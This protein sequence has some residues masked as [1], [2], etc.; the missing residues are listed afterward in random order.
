MTEHKGLLVHVYRSALGGPDTTNGGVS[1]QH[2]G[3]TVVGFQ[4]HDDAHWRPLEHQCQIFTPTELA[5]AAILVESRIPHLYGPHL[6]PLDLIENPP[7]GHVGPMMGGNYAGSSDSRWGMLGS[8][9]KGL[10]LD[11]VPIHDRVESQALY[12]A[13]SSD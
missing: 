2:D 12:N 4:R 7:E 8:M 5:P 11:V 13:L 6:V 9:F 1:A 10:R 3:L